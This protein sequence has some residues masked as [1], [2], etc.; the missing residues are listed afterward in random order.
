LLGREREIQRF[1]QAPFA[2]PYSHTARAKIR[3]TRRQR[4]WP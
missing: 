3:A 2:A 1:K 4:P